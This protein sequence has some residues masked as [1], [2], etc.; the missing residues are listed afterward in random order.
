MSSFSSVIRKPGG[1]IAP[2][3]APRRNIVRKATNSAPTP[4]P[5]TKSAPLPQTDSS[6]A[7][8]SE[9]V[10]DKDPVDAA[11]TGSYGDETS[12]RQEDGSTIRL[13]VQEGLAHNENE[14]LVET[15]PQIHPE[16]GEH[17]V[18]SSQSDS[19]SH[20]AADTRAEPIEEATTQQNTHVPDVLNVPNWPKQKSKPERNAS[21]SRLS[22][23]EA[24]NT[25]PP[26]LA[27]IGGQTTNA[28]HIEAG[29]GEVESTNNPLPTVTAPNT[30]RPRSKRKQQP[31]GSVDILLAQPTIPPTPPST[32]ASKTPDQDPA[33]TSNSRRAT[34]VVSRRC[35]PLSEAE[36]ALDS[37]HTGIRRLRELSAS[38][39][40]LRTTNQP[41]APSGNHRGDA[42]IPADDSGAAV[43]RPRKRRRRNNNTPMTVQQQA[44]QVVANVLG[45]P[46]PTPNRGRRRQRTP[47][48]PENYEIEP[49]STMMSQLC[50]PSHNFGKK[51]D[52]EKEIEANWPEILRRRKED[53]QAR[54]VAANENRRR[55]G[56]SGA[57]AGEQLQTD[58]PD[59]NVA[60]TMVIENGVIVASS[61]E[62]DQIQ[63]AQ[64]QLEAVDDAKILE[65]VDIYKRVN[66]HTIASK[67]QLP[68]GQR[69]DDQLTEMFY[70][71]LKM[72]GTDFK[73]ISNM[74]PGKTRKQVKLKYNVEERLHWS[75][76][77]RCLDQR[78]EVDLVEYGNSADMEWCNA[79][80][81]YKQMEEDEKRLREEDEARRREEGII[82]QDRPDA[83]NA[84]GEADIAVPSIE[85][86]DGEVSEATSTGLVAGDRDRQSTAAGSRLGSTT[87]GRQTAQPSGKKKQTKK[88]ASTSKRGKQAANKNKSFEG[89][90]ERLGDVGDIT[91]PG[92]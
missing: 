33:Q 40:P 37:F 16:N 29:P 3:V 91:I 24:Q 55:K 70:Q 9:L 50:T 49:E 86:P 19:Q 46:G 53:A 32:Q 60:S 30:T 88:A 52:K 25:S 68:A 72:F 35:E 64:K 71:G 2:K 57:N 87:T 31:R 59:V 75:R 62:I 73:M 13:N 78:E 18:A 79:A 38:I 20:T 54:L 11:S 4:Q 44:A 5:Q 15:V 69:W 27:A 14:S 23:T 48:D 10:Q 90:E 80:D 1:T 41:G 65:D 22:A 28:E 81:V 6:S 45:I 8:F 83:A 63:H 85:G 21:K 51:S 36:E 39:D 89:V 17:S 74:I 42:T 56:V 84:D 61:R 12:K 26:V 92:G 7:L 77:Q 76:V 67:Q 66:S 47:E 58:G 34:S 82:S 43:D